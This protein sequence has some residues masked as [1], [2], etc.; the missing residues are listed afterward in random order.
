MGI[1]RRERAKEERKVG[2][3]DSTEERRVYI[4]DKTKVTRAISCVPKHWSFVDWSSSFL[5][6]KNSL[7]FIADTMEERDKWVRLIQS[8]SESKSRSARGSLVPGISSS[9]GQKPFQKVST[10]SPDTWLSEAPLP[11]F[12]LPPPLSLHLP[13]SLSLPLSLPF[14]TFLKTFGRYVLFHTT[15]SF[16]FMIPP[17]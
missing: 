6:S 13:I 2:P 8:A 14:L 11:I 4:G 12:P 17:Y 1:S 16:V 3:I 9:H 10:F 15:L 7:R 5:G